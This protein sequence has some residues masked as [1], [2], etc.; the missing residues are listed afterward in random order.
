MIIQ[1]PEEIKKEIQWTTLEDLNKIIDT[2][3]ATSNNT[4]LAWSI[5]SKAE[6]LFSL[7]YPASIGEAFQLYEILAS[8]QNLPD[9]ILKQAGM[10]G[11]AKCYIKGWP[12]FPANLGIGKAYQI[13]LTLRNMPDLRD[14]IKELAIY[15]KALCLHNG[16]F[17][18]PPDLGAA[19]ELYV[20]LSNMPNLSDQIKQW[21]LL[22][23]AECLNVGWANH[24]R[25]FGAA[26]QLYQTLSKRPNLLDEIK[27]KIP[28][29]L[30]GY[31][32]RYPVE[33][34]LA[35]SPQI[36]NPHQTSSTN[37]S[38]D[39][40]LKRVCL[41]L[42]RLLDQITRELDQM[43][44]EISLLIQLNSSASTT[45]SSTPK[46]IVGRRTLNSASSTPPLNQTFVSTRFPT[47]QINQVPIPQ[48]PISLNSASSIPPP[49]QTFVS[50]G[51]P[52]HQAVQILQQQIPLNSASTS[53]SNQIFVSNDSPIS[54]PT[55][56]PS[57]RTTTQVYN[58]TFFQEPRPATQNPTSA[59]STEEDVEYR[60]ENSVDSLLTLSVVAAVKPEPTDNGDEPSAKGPKK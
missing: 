20:M 9:G 28:T 41:D 51:F 8:M 60:G 39:Q 38:T 43:K 11:M 58:T 5:Y 23:Q 48:R 37:Q 14:G 7:N 17:Y 57:I 31:G 53:S 12:Q 30:V 46:C 26:Y 47:Y 54:S 25:D 21:A 45:P 13:C 3:G 29:V 56:S 49:N 59:T 35:P 1:I 6:L 19:Y 36:L 50:S 55:A 44:N 33:N 24:P 34:G 42:K 32:T 4:I 2:A 15:N 18:R 27:Q 16:W 40:D 10:I 52:T 22:R